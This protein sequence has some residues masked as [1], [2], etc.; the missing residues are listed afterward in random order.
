MKTF[1]FTYGSNHEDDVGQSLG[2]CYTPIEA[3]NVTEATR[4]MFNTRGAKWSHCYN[5]KEAAGVSKYHLQER[6]LSEVWIKHD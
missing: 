2:N 3:N 5:S 4:L 1:Y 6:L